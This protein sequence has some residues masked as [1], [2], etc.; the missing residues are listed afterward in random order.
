M[1]TVIVCDRCGKKITGDPG[2]IRIATRRLADGV[3]V[4]G[5]RFDMLDFCN[6]CIDAIMDFI[7]LDQM[8]PADIPAKAAEAVTPQAEAAPQEQP[9]HTAPTTCVAPDPVDVWHEPTAAEA[10]KAVEVQDAAPPK[11]R[12]RPYKVTKRQPKVDRGK[13]GAL[14]RAGWSHAKI[15]DEMGCTRQFIGM[16]LREDGID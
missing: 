9:A 13:V 8:D 7:S 10:P 1:S 3:I 2:N 16:I 14:R 12:S 6:D 15:A 4:A 11:R 5:P